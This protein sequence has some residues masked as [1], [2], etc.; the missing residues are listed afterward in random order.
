MPLTKKHTTA[1]EADE[2]PHGDRAAPRRGMTTSGSHNADFK[3]NISGDDAPSESTMTEKDA[4]FP[5]HQDKDISSSCPES[6]TPQEQKQEQRHDDDDDTVDDGT[7]VYPKGATR[8]LIIASLCMSVFLVALDQT[9]IAPA[10]G[11]IT[12]QFV[13]V[14]DIGWYGSA[15]L[16]TTTALQPLY[17]KLYDGFP[18]KAVYLVAVFVFEAG[19][20]VCAVAPSSTAFIVGRALAGVGTAG[21]FS[22]AIVVLSYTLPL[23]RRPLAFGLIG[24]LPIGGATMVAIF[25]LL[26]VRGQ[27]IQGNVSFLDKVRK[28]DLL[29]TGVLIPAVI[30]LLLA[31]QWG[32]TEYPWGNSRIIG[33][34]VASAALTAMFIAIQIWKADDGTLPPRLFRDRNI[35]CAMLYTFLFGSAFYP[36]IYYLSVYF[37]AVGAGLKLL[38]LLISCVLT[39]I[40]SGALVGSVVGH[41]NPIV[42]TGTALFAVGAGMISHSFTLDPPLRAWLGYQALAGLGVGVGFQL[43]ILVVQSVLPRGDIPVATAC[44]QFFQSLGGAVFVAVAQTVFQNGLVEGVRRGV[45]RLDPAVLTDAGV[46]QSKE[47]LRRLGLEAYTTVVMEAYLTGLRR[48]YYI[49]V[50]CAAGAFCAAAGLSWVDIKKLGPGGGGGGKGCGAESWR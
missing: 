33:L 42:L 38:P 13:S 22:G 4:V 35:L 6:Q 36:I 43:G 31:L 49:T 39:S 48:A 27:K 32:G 1:P 28:L 14:T 17:G 20:L 12:A 11:A 2:A 50:A 24:D 3:P 18:V 40:L 47:I 21:L 10:L 23:R 45:P 15:Y 25:F 26:H 8:V 29:G 34:F 44:V 46:S 5:N 9:I 19:S 16:L 7:V 37:Q 30:S 41:Y